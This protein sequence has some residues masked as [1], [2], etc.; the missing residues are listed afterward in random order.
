MKIRYLLL[1]TIIPASFVFG[2]EPTKVSFTK[3]IRPVF[4]NRCVHCH[5]QKTL[6]DRVSF[7]NAK[8]GLGKDKWGKVYIVPGHPDQ[9]LLIRAIESPDFHEMQMPMVGLRTTPEENALIR[10]WVAEGADWPKGL[11]GKVR[12]TFRAKE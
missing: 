6:P 5:N 1:S 4:E 10:R 7:E 8:N 3:Q 2:D 12:V 11:A 9:S